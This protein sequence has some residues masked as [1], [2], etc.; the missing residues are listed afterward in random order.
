MWIK[1]SPLV[2]GI[3]FKA[4]EACVLLSVLGHKARNLAPIC[5]LH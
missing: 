3:S 4:H 2:T 5:K 1:A